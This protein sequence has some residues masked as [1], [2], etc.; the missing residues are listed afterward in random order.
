MNFI[1]QRWFQVFK[2]SIYAAVF[3]NVFL[4]FKKEIASS[5]HRYAEISSF[6]QFLEA[7]TSTIDTAAWAI[8]LFLFELETYIIPDEKFQGGLE[9]LFRIIRGFCYVVIVSSFLGYCSNYSWLQKFDAVELTTLCT[10]KG[11]SW[12]VE[13]DEFKTINEGNCDKLAK[14]Q[15]FFKHSSKAIYTDAHY[16]KES[17]WLSVIDILNSL[18]WILIVIILEI[19][20]WLQHKGRLNRHSSLLSTIAKNTLYAVLIF[21][22]IYWGIYGDFLE[23][24]DAFMWIVAFFFI[25]MNIIEWRE[26]TA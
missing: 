16:Y 5:A 9:W 14:V 19:D 15:S 22:A 20:V 11:Q 18:S 3:I 25:E 7:Y 21:A 17:I 13:L 1:K 6:S 2:Y 4:F 24:W 10:V 23:F 26:E 8:L 12:M